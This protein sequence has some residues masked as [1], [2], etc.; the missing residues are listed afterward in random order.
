MQIENDLNSL[1]V[2]QE[3]VA[4]DI[5]A[6]ALTGLVSIVKETGEVVPSSTAYDKLDN[7]SKILAYLL[8][9]Q[10]SALLGFGNKRVTASADE[11][12]GVVGVNVQR[13]RELLSRLKGK[14]LKKT[15]DGW[16]LPVVKIT[17]ACDEIINK[18]K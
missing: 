16:E 1:V 9:L 7:N 11:I 17:A 2:S 3:S 6:T 5:V 18:R 12:A 13:A 8:G 10:A 4:T 14:L 15:T